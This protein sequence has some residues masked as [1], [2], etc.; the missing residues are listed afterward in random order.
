MGI[1][2]LVIYVIIV[3]KVCD[4]INNLTN[5]SPGVKSYGINNLQN[6]SQGKRVYETFLVSPTFA[7]RGVYKP[8]SQ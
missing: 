6:A 8:L 5:T 4:G 7:I 1:A 2:A 3:N